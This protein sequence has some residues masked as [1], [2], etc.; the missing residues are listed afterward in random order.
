MK[1]KADSKEREQEEME[2]EAKGRKVNIRAFVKDRALQDFNGTLKSDG[3][4]LAS[5]DGQLQYPEYLPPDANGDVSSSYY[6]QTINHTISVYTKSGQLVWGPVPIRQIF[7]SLPGTNQTFNDRGPIV[8]YD[9]Q[10]DRW[11]LGE[12]SIRDFYPNEV[13]FLVA[14][15]SSSNPA[16]TWHTYSFQAGYIYAYPRFGVWRD[17]YCME[18]FGTTQANVFAF[19]RDRLLTGDTDRMIAFNAQEPNYGL[20]P[21]DNDGAFAPEG[22][23]G[24]FIGTND[25]T[26]GGTVQEIWI[27][28]LAANWAN[29][30]NSTFGLLEKLDVAKTNN[31]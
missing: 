4:V 17:A 8:L 29:P 20:T 16:G 14:V 27:Y 30:Q 15:S 26:Q 21:L 12:V 2:Q 7:G 9:D 5:F 31:N 28:G 18:S 22:T 25:T 24:L 3:G 6:V 10:A 1:K 11:L 13:Y 23:P 19:E